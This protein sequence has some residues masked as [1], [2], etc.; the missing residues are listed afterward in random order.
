MSKGTDNNRTLWIELTLDAPREKLWRCWA[1][2]DLLKQ[3][4]CPRPWRVSEAEID[5]RPGGTMR[6]AMR[7]P[8]GEGFDHVG[9]YLEVVPGEK[10][11][12]TDAYTAAWQPSAKPFFTAVVT[13]ADTKD[14]KTLYRAEALHW[15][16]EDRKKHEEMGFHDGWTAAARQLEELANGLSEKA[17]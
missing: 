16:E 2:A 3:W 13:F 7:G 12:F 10:I 6:T 14:G 17:A 9:V 15:S 8:D 11:V 4:F 5:V 1:E